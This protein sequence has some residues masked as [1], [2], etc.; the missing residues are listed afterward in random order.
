MPEITVAQVPIEF[1]NLKDIKRL[2][3][4]ESKVST[5]FS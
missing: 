4:S 1:D 5:T 2:K 3:P